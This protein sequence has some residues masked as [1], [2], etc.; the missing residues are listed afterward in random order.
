M[1]S[2]EVATTRAKAT[3]INNLIIVSS[4]IVALGKSYHDSARNPKVSRR[5][6]NKWQCLLGENKRS[7]FRQ[8]GMPEIR[9]DQLQE[10]VNSSATR[11]IFGRPRTTERSAPEIDFKDQTRRRAAQDVVRIESYLTKG[12]MRSHLA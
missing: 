2:A 11:R 4:N 9:S 10:Y 6:V 3:L 1:A 5:K 7:F 12:T 8:L